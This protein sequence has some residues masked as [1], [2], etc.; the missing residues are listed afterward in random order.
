VFPTVVAHQALLP[1]AGMVGALLSIAAV[2]LLTQRLTG[3][4]YRF[5]LEG[6]ILSA[7]L[8]SI[9]SL[10]LIRN[11]TELPTVL[12][13]MIGSL[14]AKVWPDWNTLWPW[15]VVTIPAGLMCA[16]A[17]NAL[18]FDDDIATGLGF[19]VR[20]ARLG[21]FLAAA[22]LTAGAVSVVGDIWFIGL[23]GPHIARRIVGH[24]G[25]RLLPMSA[26]VSALLLL[27][28][29]LLI[30][31]LPGNL[32]TVPDGAVTAMLGAPFFLYLL[33]RSRR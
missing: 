25:R 32:S 30:Q 16:R 19:R 27:L 2:Y 23:I 33:V 21:L 4:P 8:A 20:T 15:A 22:T 9:T 13:W 14:N 1:F 31:L 28:A 17:A 29:D 5:A 3:D 26:L 12:L 24:D 18:R 6:I 11:G 10:L 7:V